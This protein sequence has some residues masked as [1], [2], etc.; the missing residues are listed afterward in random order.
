MAYTKLVN[1]G[2]IDR[3]DSEYQQTKTTRIAS[4]KIGPDL[5]TQVHRIVFSNQSG[6][7]VEVIT[8]NNASNEECSMS[9]VDVYLVSDKY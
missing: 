3:G 5:Y 4:E 1:Q 8:V 9:S 2:F 7:K 6:E